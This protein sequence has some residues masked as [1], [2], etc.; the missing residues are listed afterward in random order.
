MILKE[1]KQQ[2]NELESSWYE[3]LEKNGFKDIEN[4][5][6]PDKPLNEWHSFKFTSERIQIKKQHR[7]ELEI[8]FER[9]TNSSD[10]ED[11][12]DLMVKHGN[13]LFD[14]SQI[15]LIWNLHREGFTYRKIAS[16]IGG[17]CSGIFFL[18]R[19]LKSWMNLL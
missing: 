16:Q 19:R 5:K 9:F 4:H 17:S 3:L 7:E 10:F 2:F 8:K 12:L 11:A 18:I 15:K 13:N 6:H 1:N 14:K